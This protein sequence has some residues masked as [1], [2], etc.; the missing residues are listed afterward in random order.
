MDEEESRQILQQGG[1]G[2]DRDFFF[3]IIIALLGIDC[4]LDER[5]A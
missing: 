3:G 5:A 2:D 4:W 1:L